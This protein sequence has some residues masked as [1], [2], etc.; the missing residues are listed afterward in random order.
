[1]AT[2]CLPADHLAGCFLVAVG[3]EQGGKLLL[4]A[5]GRLGEQD[6]V[7]GAPGAGNGGFYGGEVERKGGGI[8][9]F[10]SVGGVEQPLLAEIGFDEGDMFFGAAGEAEILEGFVVDREDAAGGAVFGGH[11]GDGGAVGEGER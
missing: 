9:G 6:A 2:L 10:G 8:L 4:E 1:M 7:L 3:A 11:V 5:G